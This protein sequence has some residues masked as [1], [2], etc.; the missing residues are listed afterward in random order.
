M[1]YSSLPCLIIFGI[2][3]H[4]RLGKWE[5]LQADF[6][7]P[8]ASPVFHI[9][10]HPSPRIRYNTMPGSCIYFFKKLKPGDSCNP[11]TQEPEEGR[12]P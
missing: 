11:S 3:K 9:Y 10:Y 7:V 5:V 1:V 2:L 6:D 8:A 12:L 4:S